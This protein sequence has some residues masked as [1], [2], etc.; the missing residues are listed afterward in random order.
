MREKNR[1]ARESRKMVGGN[2]EG[3]KLSREIYKQRTCQL[4]EQW[5]WRKFS[6]RIYIYIRYVICF[7][8]STICQGNLSSLRIK[9][10]ILVGKLMIRAKTASTK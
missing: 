8:L 3:S 2:K 6:E 5:L 9:H 7:R 1:K 4:N 10:P